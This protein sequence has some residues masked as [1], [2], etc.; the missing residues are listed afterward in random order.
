MRNR[1]ESWKALVFEN[2][3][4]SAKKESAK[5]ARRI[6]LLGFNVLAGFHFGTFSEKLPKMFIQRQTLGVSPLVGILRKILQR[7]ETA[8]VRMYPSSTCIIT[9]STLSSSPSSSS[10]DFNKLLLSA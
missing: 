2:A 1:V 8:N 9:V 6:S 5:D 4:V 3:K 10:I 7:Q